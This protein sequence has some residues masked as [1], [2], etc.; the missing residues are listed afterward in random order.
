MV[1]MHAIQLIILS[2]H[3]TAPTQTGNIHVQ[4]ILFLL[5]ISLIDELVV[6]LL[7]NYAVPY[8][9]GFPFHIWL[10]DVNVC[11]HRLL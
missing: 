8:L 4:H 1:H 6:F 11:C 10:I 9:F 3:C 2:K 5:Y 7:V